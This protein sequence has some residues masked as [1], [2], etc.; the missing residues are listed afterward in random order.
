[1][2]QKL[3]A[4]RKWCLLS[5]HTSLMRKSAIS[6]SL[7][8][9]CP[10]IESWQPLEENRCNL[11]SRPSNETMNLRKWSSTLPPQSRRLC[12]S[13]PSRQRLRSSSRSSLPVHKRQTVH[14]NQMRAEM[15]AK[16]DKNAKCLLSKLSSWRTRQRRPRLPKM[17]I[18]ITG[19]TRSIFAGLFKFLCI[20]RKSVFGSARAQGI[21]VRIIHKSLAGGKYHR[22]K[23]VVESMKDQYVGIVQ[24]LENGATLELDQTF[25]ETVLP[26]IGG[27]VLV[28]NGS[29]RGSRASLTA[30]NTEQFSATLKILDV[31]S[32]SLSVQC[33]ACQFSTHLSFM[34]GRHS[35]KVVPDVPYEDICKLARDD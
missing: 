5:K 23:A 22:Q 14:R 2:T 20:S 9:K 34:Q 17:H 8:S 18:L 35:G 16:A 6:A 15:R 12:P 10:A 24:C 3:C 26:S 33:F 21:V 29:Y 27:E 13:I 11:N 28:V 19:F 1:M 32:K 4:D 7:K 30:V 25:L 31:S